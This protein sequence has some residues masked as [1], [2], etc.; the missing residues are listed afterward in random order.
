MSFRSP[1]SLY[2]IGPNQEEAVMLEN[3]KAYSGFAVPDLATARDF[4]TDTLGLKV[5]EVMEGARLFGLEVG[6]DRP[7]LVYEKP[8]HA[9]ANFTILN[10]PVD[11]IDQAVDGLAS[12]GVQFERY[13]GFEQDDKGI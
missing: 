9:P 2:C 4:Y 13:D 6:G 5:A 12:R 3:S 8:D 10:F 7:V 11:D 1:G